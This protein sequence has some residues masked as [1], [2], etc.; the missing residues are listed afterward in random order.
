MLRRLTLVLAFVLAAVVGLASPAMAH[1]EL[2]PSEAVAGSTETLTFNVAYEGAAT[3]GLDVQLP[4]GASVVEV[5]EKAGWTSTTDDAENTVTWSGGSVEA[6]ETFSVVVA[7][8]D[9]PG[10]VLFPAIQETTDGPVSW[11]EEDEEE[12][13]DSFPAPRMTLLA[14]PNA[15]TTT[16][17]TTTTAEATS[18]TA[19]LPDTTVEASNEGDGDSAA[20]WLIGA[21]I[22]AILAI[23]IGGYLLK[24]RSD[25]D[26]AAAAEAGTPDD[27]AP[28][29]SP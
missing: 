13:H 7:L 3:T 21:G 6:D 27:E 12:G 1:T 9:T 5:P 14:D 22:A 20:P 17:A 29:D 16:E 23:A 11:I 19:D 2:E 24:R 18:T 25:A 28:T 26:E 8:P 10:E 15:T 4:E